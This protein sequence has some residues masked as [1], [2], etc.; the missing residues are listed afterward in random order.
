MLSPVFCGDEAGERKAEEHA[1]LMPAILLWRAGI[2][3]IDHGSSRIFTDHSLDRQ[4]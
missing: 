1:S 2:E 3:R 4:D